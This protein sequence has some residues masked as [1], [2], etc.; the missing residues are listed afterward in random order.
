MSQATG[1]SRVRGA[2]LGLALASSLVCAASA[3]QPDRLVADWFLTLNGAQCR[4]HG[5]LDDR[6]RGRGC[7]RVRRRRTGVVRARRREPRARVRHTRRRRATA[8]L[9]AQWQIERRR[10]RGRS[11]TAAERAARNVARHTP[12]CAAGCTGKACRFH[13]S[14]VAHFVRARARHARLH[15]ERAKR[16][17]RLSL[18]RRPGVALRVAGSRA[19]VGVAVSARDRAKRRAGHD[20]LREL[21]RGAPHL[22]GRS[23]SSREAAASLDGLF[24]RPL[25][26]LDARRRDDDADSGLCRPRRSAALARARV[27][28]SACH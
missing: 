3:Q 9:P 4:S 20:P 16:R 17:R 13:G 24:A 7:R 6:A 28:S 23:R 11:H 22:L 18:P 21:P 19:R 10:A 12:R 8:P 15:A 2:L 25:G 1:C 27:S 5:H 14:L 26:R